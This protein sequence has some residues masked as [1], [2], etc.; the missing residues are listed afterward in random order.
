[1]ALAE[2]LRPKAQRSKNSR[3]IVESKLMRDGLPNDRVKC[4]P[5]GEANVGI[6]ECDMA[7]RLNT[8]ERERARITLARHVLPDLHDPD[9]GRLDA[10]RIAAY[11]HVSLSSL[12]A[13]TGGSIAAI[14]KAPAANSL[15]QTLA[16][17]AQT[18][19][20][21]TEVLRSKEHV[22]AWLNSPHPDLGNRIPLQL[23]LEGHA[24]V[25]ADLVASA[26]AG[27]PS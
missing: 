25:V 27:Q 2:R 22:L 5:I 20:V 13:I 14:H 15:Q 1:L 24:G 17:V 8:A 12:A 6:Q 7:S 21:L 9:T 16:P 19:S 11:L 26:L 18:I 23:V 10:K 3:I 4:A